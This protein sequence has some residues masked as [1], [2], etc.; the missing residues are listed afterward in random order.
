[1]AHAPHSIEHRLVRVSVAT[2]VCTLITLAIQLISVPI[3][4]HFWGRD[5]YG[6]WLSVFAAFTMLRTIDYGHTLYVGNKLNVLYHTNDHEL[7]VNLASA[8]WGVAILGLIQISFVIILYYTNS[9]GIIIGRQDNL[10]YHEQVFMGLMVMSICWICSASYIG[11]VHRILNPLGMLYQSTWMMM[12]LQVA[13]FFAI[14]SAAILKFNVFH[15]AILFAIVQTGFY[16]SSAIYVKL[17]LPQYFPWWRDSNYKVGVR[18]IIYSL[19]VTAGWMMTQGGISAI[20][21]LIS[22]CLGP[23]AVPIF[24]TLRTISNLWTT[25]INSLTQPMIPELVRFHAKGECKKLITVNKV[26]WA[27]ISSIINLSVILIYPF[28]GIVFAFWTWHHLSFN[29][30]LLSLM[31]ASI[32]VMSMGALMNAFLAGINQ[33]SYIVVSSAL[34]GLLVL[35]LGWLLLPKYG[36]IGLGFA[37][38]IAEFLVLIITNISFSKQVSSNA[39]VNLKEFFGSVPWLSSLSVIVYLILQGLNLTMSRWIF[40]LLLTFVVTCSIYSWCKLDNTI[41]IR[42]KSILWKRLH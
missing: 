41:K 9:M 5:I 3:C 8:L 15:T 32:I 7:R 33:F 20:V 42:I 31:L 25:L 36:M 18:N 4:L 34:R 14:I 17:R 28:L 24:T 38:L 40:C 12:W 39:F 2:W 23:A 1:M 27:L 35:F 16:I 21:L 29:K 10:R 26:Y 13:L 22:S 11:I 6:T 19:P 30:S 37:I